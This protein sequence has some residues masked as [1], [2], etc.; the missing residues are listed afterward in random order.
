MSPPMHLDRV[1]ITGADESVRPED[2]VR[3]S[4]RYPFVEWGIL[5][6]RSRAGTSRY[7]SVTWLMDLQAASRGAAPMA[8][9][10]HICGHWVRHLLQGVNE[11][12]SW[13]PKAFE[14]VQLNFHAERTPCSSQAFVGALGSLGLRRQFI[15][16][17]DGVMGNRHLEGLPREVAGKKI[18][19][20]PLFDR[21][22]GAGLLPSSWP[23]PAEHSGYVGY[24]GGLGPENL[25]EQIE[26][27]A[28]AAGRTRF[29]IDMETRV[30]SADDRLFDLEKVE[31][32]LKTAARFVNA[33]VSA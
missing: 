20:V 3:L 13:M 6:S 32:S 24:A 17:V 7:P 2:L 5:V 18:D 10:L 27:I 25:E 12:P 30:R 28:R 14:R 33:A 15:F 9:S 21:S 8:L 11:L 16:Q 1:T 22:G 23:A 4:E 29:W 26:N 31:R 19:A